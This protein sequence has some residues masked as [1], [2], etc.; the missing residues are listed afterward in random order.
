[1]DTNTSLLSATTGT[2]ILGV[3]V[4]LYKAVNGKR[5]RS[6]CCGYKTEMDFKVDEMPPTPPSE[7]FVVENPGKNIHVVIQKDGG[8]GQQENTATH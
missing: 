7:N 4:M 8:N 3:L 6:S 5:I 2:T 1:M